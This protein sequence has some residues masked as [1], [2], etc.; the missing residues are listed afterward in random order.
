MNRNQKLGLATVVALILSVLSFISSQHRGERFERGQKF[1]PNLNPD[2]IVEATITKGDQ[3]TQ[4][5]RVGDEFTLVSSN[6]YPA[7]N[8][9]V[10]RFIRDVLGLS[11]EKQV[12]RG[13]DMDQELQLTTEFDESMR[14]Q[15][16]NAAGK[17][18]V[19]FVI[20]KSLEGGNG[21]YIKRMDGD[22]RNVYLTSSRAYLTAGDDGFLR[23][24]LLNVA[25]TEVQRIRGAGY[26]IEDQEGTLKLVGLPDG[27][28]E[29]PAVGQLKTALTNL[30]FDKVYLA[31]DAQVANLSFTQRVTYDL[32]DQSHYTLELAKSGDKTYLRISGEH[33]LRSINPSELE[34]DE[35]VKEK[36]EQ[37]EA[38]VKIQEFTAFHGSWVYELSEY[39]GKKFLATAAELMEDEE[40]S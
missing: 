35:Q 18:M 13:D 10:N 3:V 9:A 22:A 37:W 29:S 23:K 36:S 7:K 39:V 14:V 25:Q 16:K 28:K 40:K 21:S 6:G 38:A 20:G 11:L 19:D 15:F 30:S 12:G 5:K 33:D 17:Q 24:E 26:T 27:K 31:D 34:T 2:E 32:K 1:L 4:L 8:E